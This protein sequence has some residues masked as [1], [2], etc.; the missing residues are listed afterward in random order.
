MVMS[1]TRDKI[2]RNLVHDL[3]DGVKSRALDGFGIVAVEMS[4]LNP[5]YHLVTHVVKRDD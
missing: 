3:P 5:L 1:L 2:V 4:R